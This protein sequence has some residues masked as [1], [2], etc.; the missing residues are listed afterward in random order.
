MTDWWATMNDPIDG[1]REARQP[2]CG[3]DSRAQ[4]DLYMVV[5]NGGEI[6][7]AGDNLYGA[8]ER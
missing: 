3:D 8:G 4:N 2:T 6:N 5:S 7:A 1:G